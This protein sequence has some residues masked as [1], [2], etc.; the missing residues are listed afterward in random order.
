MVCRRA[1]QRPGRWTLGRPPRADA[2]GCSRQRARAKAAARRL[3][4]AAAF[5]I[6]PSCRPPSPPAATTP[7][8]APFP[9]ADLPGG[10]PA[11]TP[12]VGRPPPAQREA[13]PPAAPEAPGVRLSSDPPPLSAR[14]QWRYELIWDRGQIDA[15]SVRGVCLTHASPTQRQLGRFA[16]EL[17][18]GKELLERLR[19]DFPLLGGEVPSAA[20]EP[21]RPPPISFGPGAR[22]SAV[23]QVPHS[24]RATRA[25]IVDR[26]SGE[27]VRVAWPPADSA[28]VFATCAESLGPGDQPRE[29]P[30][31]APPPDPRPP[32]VQTSPR[33]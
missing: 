16:L 29:T 10:D 2:P 11:Q 8:P 13:P 28:R 30:L 14:R 7:A 26:A 9:A 4:L 18:V 12:V 27:R 32:G 25:Q 20:G 21:G 3:W 33:F 6:A 31:G 1:G 23:I 22:T 24:P 15:S 5:G 17:W 19:F